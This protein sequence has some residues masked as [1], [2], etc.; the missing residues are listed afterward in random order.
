MELGGG[1]SSLAAVSVISGAATVILLATPA[2]GVSLSDNWFRLLAVLLAAAVIIAQ[3][4]G[5]S[6]RRA[7]FA[8]GVVCASLPS[9]V[10]AARHPINHW[11]DFWF[12]LPN[13]LY[14]W[15]FGAL[16]TPAFP[17]V[18]S[19]LPGYP[20]GSS[21]ILAA[22]WSVAGNVVDTA[23]SQLH[24]GLLMVPSHVLLVA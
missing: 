8:L 5:F 19:F 21:V 13:A 9:L 17:P 24:L 14:I 18:A 10:I 23:R 6:S 15:K 16:P 22:V 4:R 3:A 2:G 12:W 11:D 1:I 7:A 20:P